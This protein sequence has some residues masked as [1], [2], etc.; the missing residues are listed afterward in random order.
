MRANEGF[1][2][3]PPPPGRGPLLL[4]SSAY[5]EATITPL[6]SEAMQL[7]QFY[8]FFYQQGLISQAQYAEIHERLDDLR[9]NEGPAGSASQVESQAALNQ[10]KLIAKGLFVTY[11]GAQAAHLLSILL[12]DMLENYATG[13]GAVLE[14]FTP[15]KGDED[16]GDSPDA[17]GC[18]I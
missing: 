16:P 18:S 12:I 2:S 13:S 11:V 9:I 14:R 15:G 1:F 8:S 5:S 10:L 4:R 7:D 17:P 3:P 6:G